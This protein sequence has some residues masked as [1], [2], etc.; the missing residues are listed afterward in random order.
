MIQ[1][2][3]D[4]EA[5]LGIDSIKLAQLMGELREMFEIDPAALMAQNVRT[6]RQLMD[7]LDHAGGKREWLDDR[8]APIASASVEL[9][10]R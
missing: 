8:D 4:L 6:L 7:A 1:L 5:D 10:H 9:S 3:W 2:D